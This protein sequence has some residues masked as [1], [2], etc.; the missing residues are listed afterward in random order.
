MTSVRKSPN[1]MSTTGRIPVIAA[2]TPRPVIPAS[3]I[4]E[5]STRSGPNSSTSPESTLKGVP[6]S[7]TSSP[8]TKTRSSRRSSSASASLIACPKVSSRPALGASTLGVDILIHLA[9]IREGR[10]Q[11][12]REAGFDLAAYVVLDR[13]QP[14]GVGGA[15][16]E[17]PRG[18]AGDGIP[19]VAPKLLLLPR[20]VVGAV[21]VADVVPVVAVRVAQ[22][23]RRS[24]AASRAR[25]KLRRRGVH[26]ADVLAVHVDGVNS[27]R[28][29]ARQ[30]VPRR[31]V[32][33]VGVLV[34]EVVFADVDHG[35]RPERRQVHDLVEQALSERPF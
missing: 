32:E 2:P 14:G 6:A 25:D 7:A 20:A 21:D 11:R 19:L 18:Q 17:E 10:V 27:E 23:E 26:G 22:E 4:G 34:V 28:A 8:I 16:F 3:E 9:G 12:E 29:R 30:D 35:Q 5:S 1:M 13:L 15:A 33:V 24:V 31:D